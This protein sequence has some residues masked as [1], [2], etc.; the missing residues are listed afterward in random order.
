VS[1]L[2]NDGNINSLCIGAI[3]EVVRVLELKTYFMPRCV[4]YCSI[5]GVVVSDPDARELKEAEWRCIA[6]FKSTR[7]LLLFEKSGRNCRPF[8][9]YA[10]ILNIRDKAL[11]TR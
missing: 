6:V 1:I 5:E 4:L 9:I 8:D 3:N 2:E 7:E 10:L 11:T